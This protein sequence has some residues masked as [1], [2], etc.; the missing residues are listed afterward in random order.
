[1][2]AGVKSGRNA[3][4][5]LELRRVIRQMSLANPLGLPEQTAASL[6]ALNRYQVLGLTEGASTEDIRRALQKDRWPWHL[7]DEEARQVAT[8]M[9]VDAY[10]ALLNPHLRAEYDRTKGFTLRHLAAIVGDDR[11]WWAT[12]WVMSWSILALLTVLA[13]PVLAARIIG[14]AFAPGFSEVAVYHQPL[15]GGCE[16]HYTREFLSSSGF[17]RWLLNSLLIWAVFPAFTLTIG[18]T[19]RTAAARA[20]GLFIAWSRQF[21]SDSVPRVLCLVAMVG[22]PA[23]L[24]VI[25]VVLAPEGVDLP[26]KSVASALGGT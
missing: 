26:G 5:S 10:G 25:A 22:L 6:A 23:A 9:K 17:F 15:C 16:G 7:V 8:R 2:S 24:L 20:C 14:S 21:V 4:D 13:G 1:M 19:L 18:M 12:A 11:S 3:G